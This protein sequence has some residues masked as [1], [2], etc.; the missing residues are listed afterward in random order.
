MIEYLGIFALNL[1]IESMAAWGLGR[2]KVED[3]MAVLAVNAATHPLLTI[4]L[5]VAYRYGGYS[6]TLVLVL[7]VV[8]VLVEW[9]L[10]CFMFRSKESQYLKQAIV[11]NLISYGVGVVLQL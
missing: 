3:Y 11:M 8:V 1:F 9:Q 10:L 7:E 4:I 2:R 5:M 6:L